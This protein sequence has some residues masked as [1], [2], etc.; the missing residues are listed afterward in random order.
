[1][2]D[3]IHGYQAELSGELM[4]KIKR[5]GTTEEASTYEAEELPLIITMLHTERN[6]ATTYQPK[7]TIILA[8]ETFQTIVT[9]K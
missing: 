1:M 4:A 3:T 6:T 7:G 9:F 5:I 2:V 8:L